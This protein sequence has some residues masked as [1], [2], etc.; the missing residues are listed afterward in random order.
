MASHNP[1]SLPRRGVASVTPK[2]G[3]PAYTLHPCA[4]ARSRVPL[5]APVRAAESRTLAEAPATAMRTAVTGRAIAGRLQP[6]QAVSTPGLQAALPWLWLHACQLHAT[7][8]SLSASSTRL[9]QGLRK[10]VAQST[11]WS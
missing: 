10:S 4:V 1:K 5:A 9:S 2:K 6:Y 8:T 7:L 11:T 3:L